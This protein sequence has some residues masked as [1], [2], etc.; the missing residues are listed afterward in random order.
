M[1]AIVTLRPARA[2]DADDL[3][4]WRNDPDVRSQSFT[5][6]AVTR[7]E[8]VAWLERVLADQ[9]RRLFVCEVDGQPAGQAR[10]D[11]VSQGAGEISVSL[12]PEVRGRGLGRQLIAIASRRAV[13]ELALERIVARVKTGNRASLSAFRAAGYRLDATIDDVATLTLEV[14]NTT[15]PV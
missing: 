15:S 4:R 3:L 1:T 9:T 2:E 5:I 12:A 10:I 8:H 6:E 13:Q 7:G 14:G 11:T